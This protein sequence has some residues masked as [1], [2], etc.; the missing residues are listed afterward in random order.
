[1]RSGRQ[2]NAIR[3]ATLGLVVLAVAHGGWGPEETLRVPT[4]APER[5]HLA[6]ADGPVFPAT[7]PYC[8]APRPPKT[9]TAF[10][11]ECRADGD[12]D[13][14]AWCNGAETCVAG[15]CVAGAAPCSDDG[16]WCNGV[17]ACDEAAT[18]CLTIDEPDCLAEGRVCNEIIDDCALSLDVVAWIGETVDVLA[19]RDTERY[20]VPTRGELLDFEDA[21]RALLAG[22]IPRAGESAAMI[23]YEVVP[24]LDTE[25]GDELVWGL[26]PAPE[27]RDGRGL[28]LVRPTSTTVRELIVEAPHP[29]YDLGTGVMGA[30]LFRETGARAF[31]MA[32]AHRCA[33]GE[34]T[35]CEGLS[36]VC[37][38]GDGPYRES[39]MAHTNGSFFQVFHAVATAA[40]PESTLTL[41]IHGFASDARSPTFYISDGTDYDVSDD[42]YLP[43]RLARALEWGAVARGAGRFGRSCNR[44]GDGDHYCGTYN[45]QGRHTNGLQAD[46]WKSGD[47]VCRAAPRRGVGRFVHLELSFDLRHEGG[48][49]DPS[50]VIEAANAAIPEI[51][52]LASDL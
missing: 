4:E 34:A 27:N 51:E 28:Y 38:D 26:F 39:D 21:V 47:N 1:M 19:D 52:F 23:G 14:D 17:E 48:N 30:L 44:A 46:A 35:S 11:P 31:A 33:N 29:R 41:S 15:R 36:S 32:G 42:A 25:T 6:V 37:D 13:D 10:V 43:N 22:D 49:L 2:G 50:V 8:R 40:R 24:V 9:Q 16:Q 7:A 12:C 18:A 5:A 45:T 3:L 20:A